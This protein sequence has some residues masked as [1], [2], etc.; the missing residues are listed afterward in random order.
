[1]TPKKYKCTQCGYIAVQNTNHYGS[2]W[3]FGHF[4]VCPQCPPYKK[5]PEYGGQTIWE[6]IENENNLCDC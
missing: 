4:N 2:T 1:M 6:C 5:Y 3:S